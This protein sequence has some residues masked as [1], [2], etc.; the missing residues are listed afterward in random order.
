[1]DSF[2]PS[3]EIASELSSGERL[4]WAGRPRQ[5]VYFRPADA[6]M[7]PFSLL[8]GGFAIF[9]EFMAVTAVSS[10]RSGAHPHPAPLVFPL[11][12]IPFVL[13]GLYL[14]VGRF[15]FDSRQRRKTVYGLSDQRVIIKSGSFGAAVKSISLRTI[16]ELSFSEDSAGRGTIIFGPSRPLGVYSN[17]SWPGAG[18]YSPPSF[19]SIEEG[20]RVYELIRSAQA[21]QASS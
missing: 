10:P 20:R 14:I 18:Q 11:F 3:S 2:D 9:W 4:L 13:I 5:G 12:G 6:V 21:K 15:F 8:W 17:P 1:M 19:E 7:I 16:S